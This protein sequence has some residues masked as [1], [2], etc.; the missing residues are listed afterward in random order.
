MPIYPYAAHMAEV[1]SNPIF[2][3]LPKLQVPGFISFAA[4]VPSPNSYPYADIERISQQ[5]LH[6]N[7][8][9]LLQYGSTEGYPPLR[10]SAVCLFERAGIHASPDEIF[11]TTGGQ[12]MIDLLCKLFIEPNDRVLVEMPTYSATLQI[13]NAYRA[14]PIGLL[15]DEEGV[16]V[17]DLEEKLKET[18]P[19]FVYIIPTFQNPSGRTLSLAC[20]KKVAEITARYGVML[21]EDD[22]YRDLR[23]LGEDLPPIKTFDEIGNVFY[24]TSTSKILCP[25]LRVGLSKVPS[26]DLFDHLIVAKQTAD[27][28]TQ[29]SRKH[30]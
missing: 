17:E 1:P 27:M 30:S 7:A 25:G 28:H 22:P 29:I 24:M 10:E 12:Q 18:H 5:V 11:I 21:V 26:R 20:R 19:K 23:Y 3:L 4:G 8:Q 14:H 13:M 9:E 6:E 16:I 15:S 2:D